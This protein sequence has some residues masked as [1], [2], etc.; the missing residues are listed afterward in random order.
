MPQGGALSTCAFT[1]L[2]MSF[3]CS[4]ELHTKTAPS[5]QQN[6][7]GQ[8]K[9]RRDSM[10]NIQKSILSALC[11][12]QEAWNT[13]IRTSCGRWSMWDIEGWRSLFGNRSLWVIKEKSP[14]SPLGSVSEALKCRLCKL[15]YKELH[16]SAWD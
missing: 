1:T 15:K 9:E 2:K 10:S 3:R 16:H 12:L 14:T 7:N 13:H 6:S 5:S 4:V 8:K 11:A